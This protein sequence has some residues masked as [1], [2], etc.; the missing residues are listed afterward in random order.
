METWYNGN[1]KVFSPRPVE[2]RSKYCRHT[3]RP[4]HC[5]TTS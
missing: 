3:P 5:N 1:T 4:Y 2:R